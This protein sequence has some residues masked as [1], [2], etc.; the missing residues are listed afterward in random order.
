MPVGSRSHRHVSSVNFGPALSFY[1]EC[2]QQ[3]TLHIGYVVIGYMVKS[4]IQ[5]M[6]I[7]SQ[8]GPYYNKIVRT[9][10]QSLGWS[11]LAGQNRGMYITDM[12]C[13]FSILTDFEPLPKVLVLLFLTLLLLPLPL[14]RLFPLFP[15]GMGPFGDLSTLSKTTTTSS[16]PRRLLAVAAA[17]IRTTTAT[18]RN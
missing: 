8:V 4:A 5:S 9:Y 16:F 18:A 15:F 11:I 10:G 13:T 1:C 3:V 7:W 2:E 12:Q 14:L 6:F 17:A